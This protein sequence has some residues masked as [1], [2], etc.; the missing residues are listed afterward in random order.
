MLLFL[1]TVRIQRRWNLRNEVNFKIYHHLT[2]RYR[3]RRKKE[4]A[5]M[6]LETQS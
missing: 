1:G 4:E 2:E 3:E 5:E 6:G